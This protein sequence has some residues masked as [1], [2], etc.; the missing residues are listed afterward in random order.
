LRSVTDFIEQLEQR[1]GSINFKNI[2]EK[3]GIVYAKARLADNVKGFYLVSNS[4]RVIVID[5]RLSKEQRRDVGMHEL[6][7]ALKSPDISSTHS[8]KREDYK[9]DLFSALVRAPEVNYGDTME[10]LCERYG[11][12]PLL[13]KLRIE[14]EKKKLG[15]IG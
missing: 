7:H 14:Y 15:G 11:V 2:C 6:Y 9:A 8:T 4:T 3:E 5:E 10:T 13:A 1:Y 12:S